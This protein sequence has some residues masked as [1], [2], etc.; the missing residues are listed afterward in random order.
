MDFKSLFALSPNPYV[1]LDPDLTIVWMNDAY[2]RATLRTREDITGRGIFDAFPSEP[3]TESY[4]LLHN[5]LIRVLETGQIDEIAL[6]RYDIVGPDG[7][8]IQKF[9]SATHTPILG[10]DGAVRHI[11]QHTVDVTELHGL[12]RMRDEMGLVQRAG[13]VQARNSTLHAQSERMRRLVEQAPGFVAVLEGRDHVFQLANA[14]YRTLV[15]REDL[16]GHPVARVLPEVVGQGFVHR[17]DEVLA[18]GKPYFGRGEEIFIE[19][20]GRMERMFLDFIYQPI[21][22]EDREPMGV[23]VQGYDVTE[24]VEGQKRQELLMSELNHRVKNTLAVVQG[25]AGQSFRSVDPD[26]AARAIFSKRLHALASAHDLLTRRN[27]ESTSLHD[28]L[29]SAISAATGEEVGRFTLNGP[30]VNLSP[31]VGVSLAMTVH[32]LCTNAIKYGALSNETG[33]VAVN[34]SCASD[35]GDAKA[36]LAIEWREI[37]GPAV[38]EPER[39]GF[40]TRLIEHGFV[41]QHDGRAALAYRPEGLVCTIELRLPNLAPAAGVTRSAADATRN[42]AE[43]R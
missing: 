5:S 24:T 9:W 30:D 20:D 38:V 36:R 19:I 16:I 42:R 18:T 37:G 40:G 3:G 39:T 14:A 2:L 1:V 10:D 41:S 25:L 4:D 29:H 26:G 17:L 8:M 21:F 6:I 27:W 12:R 32:E 11:L 35:E 33:R 23:Y 15:G 34:W 31:E 43:T 13:A 7:T 28:C 22:G